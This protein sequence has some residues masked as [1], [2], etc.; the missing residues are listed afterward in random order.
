MFVTVTRYS[1][2]EPGTAGPPPTTTTSF[3]IVNC[4]TAPTTTTVG[5]APF[6]GLPSLSVSS[7]GSSAVSTAAWLTIKVPSGVPRLTRSSYSTTADAPGAIV[8]MSMPAA[9]GEAPPS[10]RPNGA[11]FNSVESVT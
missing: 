10:G 11:L 1:R 3:V 6:A 8:P 4:W 9:N 2:V 7:C 5:W